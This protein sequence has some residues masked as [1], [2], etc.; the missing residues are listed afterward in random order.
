MERF[1]FQKIRG[2]VDGAFQGFTRGQKAMMA[3]AVAAV[4]VGMFVFTRSQ[5]GEK[6]SPLF[7]NLE[8]S[9]ASAITSKLDAQRVHY[10]LAD[11]GKAIL[12]PTDD[13][14]R[15]RLSLNADG[16]PSGGSDSFAL[17]DKEGITT[18]TF[19][20][21]TDY[22]RALAGEIART[23]E[24][25]DNVE[26]AKV[27]LVI[28]T[29]DVFSADSQKASA[30]V[31]LKTTGTDQMSR[32][33]AKSVA[34]L[35]ASSVP[36]LLV[37]NV[38][39]TDASG[40]SLWMGTDTADTG[41]MTAE[42][43]TQTAAFEQRKAQA[44]EDMLAKVVGPNNVRATVAAELDFT[45]KER[46]QVQYSNSNPG[47]DPLINQTER[48]ST[49]YNTPAAGVVGVLGADGQPLVPNTTTGGAAG[50]TGQKYE[51]RTDSTKYAINQVNSVEKD[52]PGT[53]QRLTIAVAVNQNSF[54]AADTEK[55]NNLVKDASGFQP[56]RDVFSGVQAIAF[57][58]SAANAAKKELASATSDH[59]SSTGLF[60]GVLLLAAILAVVAMALWAL[61]R[62]RNPQVEVIDLRELEM[63]RAAELEAGIGAPHEL[64]AAERTMQLTTAEEPDFMSSPLALGAAGNAEDDEFADPWTSAYAP[65]PAAALV[66]SME[67]E[68]S[69]LVD[70]QSEDV[71]LLLRNWMGDRRGV[72]R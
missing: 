18:S 32:D 57:D 6:M 33:Q 5:G 48:A 65:P 4:V 40:R 50:T 43:A 47:Q 71:A 24:A 22:Q 67:A 26:T 1:D 42:Q 3:L 64:S 27:N 69:N 51:E 12:V 60:Q 13:V 54:S 66:E 17:L 29:D 23:I 72:T 8:A 62:S 25:M 2:R 30:S 49:I 19:K 31:F 46:N 36:E 15:L 52:A 68:I 56:T 11:Q 38:T 7:T 37:D 35:V 45:Q 41:P 21:R 9:D 61:R 14:Y 59:K 39:I 63:M 28:P 34:H 44:I 10:K 16:L 58:T 20:Q 53:V 55:L 70:S